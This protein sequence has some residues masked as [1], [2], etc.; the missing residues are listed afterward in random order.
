MQHRQASG[1]SQLK[2][3]RNSC[4]TGSNAKKCVE[5]KKTIDNPLGT[6]FAPRSRCYVSDEP[7]AAAALY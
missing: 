6:F 2:T 4:L 5:F 1:F 3:F 7:G